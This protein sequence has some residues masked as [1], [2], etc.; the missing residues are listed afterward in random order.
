MVNT[1]HVCKN[2]EALATLSSCLGPMSVPFGRECIDKGAEPIEMI[3]H[4]LTSIDW[5]LEALDS[6]VL[7]YVSTYY[8]DD[9]R[10]FAE[11]ARMLKEN[12]Q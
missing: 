3:E 12:T 2:E 5:N 4:L 7:D 8:K 10:T 6:F 9:Y 1:C 11:A